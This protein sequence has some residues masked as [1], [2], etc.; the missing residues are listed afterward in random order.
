MRKASLVATLTMALCLIGASSALAWNSHGDFLSCGE[1]DFSGVSAEH[2]WKL[3]QTTDGV[4]TKTK[5]F[6]VAKAGNVSWPVFATLGTH[7]VSV[8]LA[9]A[10]DPHDGY[11][12][13]HSTFIDCVQS[14]GTPGPP[15]PVG[16]KG[17]PGT[18]YDCTG[19][20]VPTG[21]S[22]ALCPG[23]T[24]NNPPSLAKCVSHRVYKVKV[25]DSFRG[26]KVH[27]AKLVWANGHRHTT[28]VRRK[29]GRLHAVASFKG[30]TSPLR[31]LWTITLHVVFDGGKKATGTR[32]VRLCAPSDGNLNFFTDVHPDG[33]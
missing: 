3:T 21:G 11:S 23:K 4:V 12:E 10:K 17:D 1:A 32:N 31:G 24:P 9:N 27:T 26:Q 30:I 2:G 7:Y 22:P 29:D 13:V 15:G 20:A 33:V 8:T 6:D 28:A 18:G 19:T 5:V 25:A 16:P 14:S